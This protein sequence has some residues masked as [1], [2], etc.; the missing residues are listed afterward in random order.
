MRVVIVGGSG[1]VG[2]A[3]LARLRDDP[4]VT[5]VRALARRVPH[6]VPPPPYDIAEWWPVDLAASG[7]PERT[8][9]HLRRAFVGAD[10][11]L[12]VAWAI[13][14]G[15]DR[16]RLR[17]IN[18]EGTAR[19][20]SAAEQAGVPHLV[21][22][23]SF[24]AYSPAHDDDPRAENWPTDGLRAS[25]YS[26]DKVAQE[27]LLDEAEQRGRLRVARVRPALVFHRHAGARMRRMAPIRPRGH[28][29]VDLPDL[30]WPEGLRFQ[31]IHADDLAEALR[32]VVVRQATG[33]FNLAAPGVA[34]APDVAQL[35]SGGS[36]RPVP[37]EGARRALSWAWRLRL[38]PVGPGWLDLVDGAPLL[39]TE[40]AQRELDFRPRHTTVQALADLVEGIRAGSGTASPP[41]KP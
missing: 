32:E 2:T 14:P 15:H 38:A 40:R 20:V 18:V 41:L 9:E 24:G 5:S 33:A 7:P 35:V 4:S 17:R 28:L 31:A 21:V 16:E 36:W 22:V 13:A 25:D 12:H 37:Y 29:T 8:V 26:Q 1:G 10:A 19:V 6:T 27:R 34:H 39:D 30:P 11:V 3:V 23:S